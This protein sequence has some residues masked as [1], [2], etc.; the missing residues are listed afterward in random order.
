MVATYGKGQNPLMMLLA[1]KYWDV[2]ET[3]QYGDGRDRTTAPGSA[4]VRAFSLLD[5]VL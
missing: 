3:W 1:G 4:S 5:Y 2:S